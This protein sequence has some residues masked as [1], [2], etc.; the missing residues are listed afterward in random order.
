VSERPLVHE[1]CR[2]CRK[3]GGLAQLLQQGLV[4]PTRPFGARSYTRIIRGTGEKL[5]CISPSRSPMAF[6][7]VAPW[8]ARRRI[9]S[10]KFRPGCLIAPF[11]RR[12]SL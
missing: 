10:W 6:S 12:I 7:G 1:A 8:M 9:A 2:C 3:V 5:R 11:A 4:T